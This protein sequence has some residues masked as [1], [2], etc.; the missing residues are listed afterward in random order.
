ME[1]RP[2]FNDELPQLRH[3][4]G[5]H[6]KLGQR[7]YPMVLSATN[8]DRLVG[9]GLL[10]LAEREFEQAA[11]PATGSL[12]IRVLP[13]FLDSPQTSN[14][15]DALSRTAREQG[16]AALFVES[17][18]DHPLN[19]FFEQQGFVVT[20][21]EELWQ[22][23]LE[24]V[25]AR[26][27]PV[28]RRMGQPRDWTVRGLEPRDIDSLKTMAR[29]YQFISEEEIEIAAEPGQPGYDQT[30]STVIRQG[31][32]VLAALLINAS[33]STHFHT[34]I[35]MVEPEKLNLSGRL[36][37]LLLARTVPEGIRAGYTATTLT[38]Q[39]KREPE[40]LNLAKRSG[41]RCLRQVVVLRKTLS[42]AT[43]G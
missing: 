29:H 21:E 41:G 10:S 24:T 34:R 15:L 16:L 14:L 26:I 31:S 20:K 36:N 42:E 35:R 39:R 30:L 40:T 12:H 9:A 2:P 17:Q 6:V 33:A 28:A 13:A 7:G 1:I 4:L 38:F 5:G 25:N 22:V 8:P 11:A 32:T 3:F 37:V 23:E 18:Q 43:P 27:Q 19:P